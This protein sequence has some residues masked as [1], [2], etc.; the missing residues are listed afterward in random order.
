[1]KKLVLLTIISAFLG[2][3]AGCSGK[4]EKSEKAPEAVKAAFE[5]VY[6]NVEA[7]WDK[8]EGVYQAEFNL[9][10]KELSAFFNETGALLKT[11]EEIKVAEL[12]KAITDYAIAQ[13]LGKMEE[14]VKVTKPDGSVVYEL[15]A[16][17]SKLVFDVNGN[18]I[19]K[20]GEGNNE[21]ET[22]NNSVISLSELPKAVNDFVARNYAG[23]KI[24]K[25]GHD[26][27]CGGGDAMDVAISKT[28]SPK[29]SLIFLPD[30]KFV[31]K[32]E[33]IA[34]DAVPAKILNTIKTK[35][36]GFTSGKEAE[37]LT[38]A[39]NK[40]VQFQLDLKKERTSKEVTFNIDGN[41]IC[42]N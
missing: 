11:E 33:D 23:Y 41:V 20:T 29:L 38:L 10:G 32:E 15:E 24:E 5:K 12:P 25:A 40:T 18:P 26:P 36:A 4:S 31:Q 1:M 28:G 22:E 16:N 37:K 8:K 7:D 6:P 34:L 17:E 30:G 14:T 2:T 35:Y 27:L 42:E 21:V 39:D 13:K 9:N 3:M 19:S